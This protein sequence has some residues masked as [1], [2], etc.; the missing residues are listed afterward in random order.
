MLCEELAPFLTA[1]EPSYKPNV[2][3][4]KK[5]SMTLWY[6]ANTE[7]FRLIANLYGFNSKG[8]AHYCVMEVLE[9][10][11]TKLF[12]QYIKWPTDIEIQ[13]IAAEFEEKAGFPNVIGCIDG[14]HISI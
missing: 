9:A 8:R 3:P 4:A 14:T 11:A 5:I 13:E 2:C 6:L 10:M 1:K 7:V 12:D